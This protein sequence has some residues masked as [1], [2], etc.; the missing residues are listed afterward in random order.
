[1]HLIVRQQY[2]DELVELYGTPDIKVITGIRRSGKSVLLQ[3]FI[4]YLE[5]LDD[6]INIVMINLQEL[7]FD[8]LL[9]YHA[10][11]KYILDQYKEGMTNVLLIDEVQLCQQF[12]RAINSIYTK[13]IYDI[14]ITG[15]NAFLLSS[16]LATLFTGRTIEIK[17]FPFSFKEYLAYYEINENYD[18]AFD[19]YVRIGGMPGAYVYKNESRQYDYIKDVYSTI[20]IRDLVEKYKIRNKQE[21]TNISEFMMDNIGNLLSPNNI[22]KA[23]K[24]NQSEITR[25]TVSK[26][27][28]Y[29]ENAFLF[30]EAKRYDLKGKKYLANNSKYYLCDSSFRYA[31][32]G[33]R[34]MDFGRVY[35][36]IVYL[37]LLRR[38][39]EVYV[40]KLYKKEVDFV[41]KKRDTQ[42]YI[43]VSDNIADNKTFEREYSPL[44]AIKDAY[45]K[46]IIARTYHENYDYQG[47]QV[48]DIRRWLQE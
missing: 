19:Q 7:E 16:D 35:E 41:A 8:H 13:R 39:Y 28:G 18:E 29:L 25:K 15:S 32:N 14:Y 40:G 4:S 47:I 43:Q 38:G 33:T 11:H 5:S 3:E 26:Y 46:M 48:I 1:M 37:E 34:N 45:P 10:L 42:I 17:V 31:I 36:N 30:Y 44:L 24:N 20:L 21:F 22:S 9:E 27:I 2:L 12:E 6:I 23:L